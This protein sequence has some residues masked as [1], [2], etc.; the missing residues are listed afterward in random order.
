MTA[1]AGEPQFLEPQSGAGAGDGDGDGGGGGGADRMFSKA[2]MAAI[3]AKHKRDIEGRYAGFDEI[4]DKATK[5]D[6]LQASTK[7]ETQ[8]LNDELAQFRSQ[9]E[10]FQSELAWRDTLLMR[11]RIA[12]EKGLD[13]KLWTRIKGETEDE[14]TADVEE[15]RGL[16]M[17]VRPRTPSM[18]SGA[19]NNDGSTTAKERAVEA[20]RNLRER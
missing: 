2:E 6:Q 16:A 9:N 17:P 13:P 19:S 5:Y 8:R 4:K 18:R 10:T 14:I 20:L 15:L 7:T 3:M 12:S 1:S 11:Q